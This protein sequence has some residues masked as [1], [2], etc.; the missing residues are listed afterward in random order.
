MG[1]HDESQTDG[2]STEH[3]RPTYTQVVGRGVRLVPSMWYCDEAGRLFATAE[4]PVATPRD[5]RTVTSEEP[6][7]ATSDE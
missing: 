7:R 6:G 1:I 4:G 3:D 2:R 5:G